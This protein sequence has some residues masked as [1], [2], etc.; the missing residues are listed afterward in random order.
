LAAAFHV[1]NVFFPMD[2]C[3][4]PLSLPRFHSEFQI[5]VNLKSQ[6]ETSTFPLDSR[7]THEFHMIS[8]Q[9]YNQSQVYFWK[10]KM[11]L[12]E[13][14]HKASQGVESVNVCL[15]PAHTCGVCVCFIMFECRQLVCL[16]QDQIYIIYSNRAPLDLH[17][18]KKMRFLRHKGRVSQQLKPNR[19]CRLLL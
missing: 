2:L 8:T 19:S 6:Q 14:F 15:M 17:C 10:G 11:N 3:V 16:P 12:N 1:V 18:Y 9:N 13:H 7:Q 4:S 5:Q